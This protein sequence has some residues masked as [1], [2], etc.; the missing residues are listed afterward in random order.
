MAAPAEPVLQPLDYRRDLEAHVEAAPAPVEAA[1]GQL[2]A[3][4]PY[5][6]RQ[7][8]VPGGVPTAGSALAP[9]GQQLPLPQPAD[10]RQFANL[11]SGPGP[12]SD[13]AFVPATPAPVLNYVASP[14][15]QYT[16]LQT[17]RCRLN[18][19]ES[20]MSLPPFCLVL[21][22]EQLCAQVPERV[23]AADSAEQVAGLCLAWRIGRPVGLQVVAHVGHSAP[24]GTLHFRG[25][26]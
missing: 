26:R 22:V 17:G 14:V 10:T 23:A 2:P 15:T 25:A 13:F 8:Q 5:R 6:S 9:L 19:E 20:T 1:G 24:F 18:C 7:L 21:P 11:P 12:A 16:A 4:R 3:K